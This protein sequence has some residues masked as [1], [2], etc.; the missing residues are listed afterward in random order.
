MFAL[1]CNIGYRQYCRLV[2]RVI[3]YRNGKLIIVNVLTTSVRS[4]AKCPDARETDAKVGI[5]DPRVLTARAIGD[6]AVEGFWISAVVRSEYSVSR[7]VVGHL[8]G[9]TFPACI[10]GIT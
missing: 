2:I 1:G 8:P 3:V 7:V 10:Y 5:D 9:E 4:S 6:P